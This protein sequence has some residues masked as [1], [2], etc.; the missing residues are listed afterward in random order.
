MTR[1]VF[2]LETQPAGRRTR[3]VLYRDDGDPSHVY[4][5][6]YTREGDDPRGVRNL[7]ALEEMRDRLSAGESVQ[8]I[9]TGT[10][11]PDLAH[12]CG[13]AIAAGCEHWTVRP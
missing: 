4:G 1:G 7:R 6:C 8:E 5:E 11:D 13:L 9:R 12:I 10:S 3:H 2:L